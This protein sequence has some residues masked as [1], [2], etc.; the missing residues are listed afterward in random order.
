MRRRDGAVLLALGVLLGVLVGTLAMPPASP[1]APPTPSPTPEPEVVFREGIVGQ[2][3]SPTPV[4]ARSQ[5]DRDIVALVFRG[6]VRLGPG[7]SV[8]PDLAERWE[9]E[10]QGRRWTFHLRQ[11]AR[12]QDGQPVTSEDVLFTV[13][14]LQSTTSTS[15]S[16]A[17]W[18]QVSTTALDA[19]TVR[20]DL[21]TPVVDFIEAALQPLLPAHLLG[22]VAVEALAD[23]PFWRSPIGSG[24][25]VLVQW[26]SERAV[27]EP[28]V[29]ATTDVTRPFSTLA[30]RQP[31]EA[32]AALLPRL[33]LRFY[34]TADELAAAYRAGEVDS[35][36]GLSGALANDVVDTDGG[37]LIRY[38]GTTLTSVVLN[39]RPRQQ[40]EFADPRT[41][42]ALLE[43]VDRDAIVA[44]VLAGAGTRADSAIPPLSWAF[45]PDASKPIACDTTAAAS[46]LKAVGWTRSGGRWT[47]PGGTEP[48]E[49]ELLVAVSAANPVV[50]DIA[51]AVA[52]AWTKLGLGVTVTEL[53]PDEFVARLADGDFAAA[54]MDVNVGLDPDLY[55]LLA[56]SQARSGGSNVAGVQDATLDRALEAARKPASTERR[57]A[58]LASLQEVLVARLPILPLVFRDHVY[59]VPERLAG[60]TARPLSDAS[61]RFWDV[62]TWRLAA[63]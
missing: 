18:R 34:A 24:P 49:V 27:L 11:D 13:R 43:A 7:Q 44:G 54:V 12:W 57:K 21:A 55:P 9:M 38:P 53:P 22:S 2:P 14:A 5:A 10:S 31:A 36:S 50:R 37:R 1:A 25:F 45:D 39:L 16:A 59:V 3:V 30:A 52:E 51:A 32:A 15:P 63:R 40:P 46:D 8:L 47:A 28:L 33:E 56:A 41:R 58:A 62:L 19:S 35:A 60:P 4:S 61:G 48:F 42:R 23:H 26:D 17:A 6:L 20:F 29:P